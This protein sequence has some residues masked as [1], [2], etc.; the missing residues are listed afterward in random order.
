MDNDATRSAPAS[1]R[2]SCRDSC[3]KTPNGKDGLSDTVILYVITD[4]N[5]GGVPLH[6]RRLACAMRDR[7][8]HPHVV[9]L[10]SVGPV[11]ERLRVDGIE[12]EACSGCCGW[13]FRVIPRLARIIT[14]TNP[15]IVHSLLFHANLAVR[16]AAK[17]ARFPAAKVLCEIQ[18]V[19][20]ER[21]WHL[22]LDRW[23]HRYCRYTIANS[24]SVLEHL[25][26]RAR[27]PR[28]H[29]QLVPGGIDPT[30]LQTAVPLTRS[31]LGVP[32]D[33]RVVLWVGRLDPVKGLHLLIRAFER[34]SE[35]T[36][37]HLVLLGDG[38][39][40]E[41]LTTWIGASP[42]R[43]R[44]HLVGRHDDVPRWLKCADLFVFPSR[45]EGLPNALLEA[46]AAGCPIVTTNVAGCRDL[47][48]DG[49]TGLVVPYPDTSAL[50]GAMAVL[51]NDR[52]LAT[53]LGHSAQDSVTR[54]WHIDQTL[55]GY[56]TLYQAALSD[57]SPP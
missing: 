1:R 31:E 2:I 30:P 23:T 27:I 49:Q 28:E 54:N 36:N 32:H 16:L 26:R 53:K 17:Y 24:P 52:K 39:L 15:A 6:V 25:A 43:Q 5:V 38:P 51:L 11:G 33:A 3:I 48:Q 56:D 42:A 57:P 18:T 47:I 45:T 34:V 10:A 9:S 19:E 35:D 55:D 41:K 46:M 14:K 21:A 4:L 22:T 7:G 13:D 29:L 20:V 37:A 12:V 50:A 44:V 8:Y 40:R